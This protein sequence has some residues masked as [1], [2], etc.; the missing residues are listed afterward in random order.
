MEF[1]TVGLHKIFSV[2][3][4]IADLQEGSQVCMIFQVCLTVGTLCYGNLSEV[5]TLGDSH[6]AVLYAGQVI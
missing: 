6:P 2:L 3:L 5:H 4:G 1:L